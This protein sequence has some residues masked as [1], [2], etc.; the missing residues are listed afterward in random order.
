MS[1]AI[2]TTTL[3]ALLVAVA[4]AGGACSPASGP[5]GT[6][7]SP[8]ASP[9]SSDEPVPTDVA[10]ETP[11]PSPAPSPTAVPSTI[12]ERD[13]ERIVDG[14]IVAGPIRRGNTHRQADPESV[15]RRHDRRARLL[16]PGI[17]HRQRGP[18][19]RPARGP[20]DQGRRNRRHDGAAR[21]PEGRRAGEPARDVHRDP[22]RD[23]TPGRDHHRRDRHRGPV[24]GVR[25]RRWVVLGAGAPRPGRLHPHAVP[26]GRR[27]P[28]RDR[29]RAGDHVQLRG[30]GPGRPGR[31]RGLPRRPARDLRG[32]PGLGRH[33]GQPRGDQR[34]RQRLRGP[35][36]GPGPRRRGQGPR[37]RAGHGLLRDRLLG[38]VRAPRSATTSRR[39]STARCGSSSRRPRTAR[40]ST[41][42]STGSG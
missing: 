36:P 4:L 5:L 30:R 17:V 22:G 23:A 38:H 40:R 14:A 12:A 27:G 34:H 11:S 42:P 18:R 32:P 31:P 6:P 28:V 39:P 21:G 41:S 25:E 8:V 20:G 2:R 7:A 3:V 16:R 35:V 15:A 19:P 13:A 1:T 10:P 33:R 26:D 24:Q 37:G 29:R 9:A